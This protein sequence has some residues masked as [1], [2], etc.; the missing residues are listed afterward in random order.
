MSLSDHQAVIDRVFAARDNAGAGI[1]EK[2]PNLLGELLDAVRDAARQ[3]TS[4]ER[5]EGA[6]A[7]EVK[8]EFASMLWRWFEKRDYPFSGEER[9]DGLTADDF[10]AMLDDH[11]AAVGKEGWRAMESA[12]KDGTVIDVWRPEG[13]RDTVYWGLPPHEC[14]EMGQYCDSDWHRIRAPGWVCSTFGEFLGRK[15]APFT[16]WMPLPAAP[17]PT[18]TPRSGGEG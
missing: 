6:T 2:Y 4:A 13:G 17:A 7:G 15:H 14:G 8:D 3:D 10:A 12:P 5:A 16:H 1:I 18:E 11:E 9:S